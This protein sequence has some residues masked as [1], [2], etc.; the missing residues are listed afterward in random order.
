MEYACTRCSKLI[1][2][3]SDLV[4]V[5]GAYSC[6]SCSEKFYTTLDLTDPA[7]TAAQRPPIFN[8]FTHQAKSFI[9]ETL[10]GYHVR[11]IERGELGEPSKIFEEVEE[12]RDSLEQDVSVMALVELSD[13]MG[14]IAAYLEKYHPSITMDDL[15]KMRSVTERAFRN[16]RR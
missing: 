4:I 10:P 6:K 12:F 13:L 15:Q 1:P 5:H 9:P 7:F 16:G 2:N 8:V 14:A 3:A 11:T